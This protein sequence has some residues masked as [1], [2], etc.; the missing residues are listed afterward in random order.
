MSRLLSASWLP[1]HGPLSF[2]MPG[3]SSWAGIDKTMIQNIFL[4][5]SLVLP[6]ISLLKKQEK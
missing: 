1:L 5:L 6:G 3:S 4:S 2:S